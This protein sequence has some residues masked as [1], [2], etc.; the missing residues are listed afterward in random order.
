[1]N[2]IRDTSEQLRSMI[3][4]AMEKAVADYV[5]MPRAVAANSGTSALH[6]SAMAAGIRRGD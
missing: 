1:M 3:R 4:S 2:I 5:H 6:L